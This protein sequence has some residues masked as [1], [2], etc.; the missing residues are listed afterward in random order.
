[1]DERE[2]TL[3][4]TGSAGRPWHRSMSALAAAFAVLTWRSGTAG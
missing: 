1:M 2:D 3:D 4:L